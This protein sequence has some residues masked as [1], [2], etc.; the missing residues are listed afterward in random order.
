MD[1]FFKKVETIKRDMAGIKDKMAEIDGMHDHSKWIVQGREVQQHREAMQGVIND[2]KVAVKKVKQQ[3]A[4]IDRNNAEARQKEGKGE[5]TADERT[6][7][8]MTMG[9]NKQLSELVGQFNFLENK[10]RQE[11]RDAVQKRVYTVTG[12]E[13]PEEDIDQLIATGDAERIFQQAIINQG[14]GQLT[15]NVL[16]QISERS[17][18][19]RGIEASLVE[20]HQMFL[21]LATLVHEQGRMLDNIEKN[22]Q[23][24]KT[25]VERGTEELVTAKTIQKNTRK[26]KLWCFIVLAIIIVIVGVVVAVVVMN[27]AKKAQQLA[28]AANSGRRLLKLMLLPEQ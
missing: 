15:R 8:N 7:T 18:A 3:L 16:A 12:Q 27:K 9:L 13:L 14:Q 10:M 20:L 2:T 25:Y 28:Q 6:R 22:V 23:R 26:W 17:R 1:A 21:D 24:S 19:V 11:N 5:G 4:D